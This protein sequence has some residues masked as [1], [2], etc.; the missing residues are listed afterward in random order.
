MPE[1]FSTVLLPV[2][3]GLHV[4]RYVSAT[5]MVRPPRVLVAGKPGASE[6]LSFLFSPDAAENTLARFD[7]CVAIRATHPAVVMVTSMADPQCVST[8]IELKLESLDRTEARAT[9][10]LAA[11]APAANASSRFALE[12]HVQKIGD[13]RAGASGWL[14]SATGADRIECFAVSWNESIKGV[15]LNYGCEMPGRGRQIAR[16][17]G[18]VVGTKGQSTAISRIFFELTGA[19]ATDFEFVV[20]AAFRGAPPRTVTGQKVE[21]AGPTGQ[22][23]LT[24]LKVDLRERD[25]DEASHSGKTPASIAS[26]DPLAGDRNKVRVFRA[27]ALAK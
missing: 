15:R 3:K 21:L 22:E 27:A 25:A 7:E 12:G 23:P 14:G 19:Q 5:D 11:P 8:E 17:P 2:K 16:I 6:G 10:D 24:G 4:L 18:Q 26:Q 20:T 1:R 9:P 13:T